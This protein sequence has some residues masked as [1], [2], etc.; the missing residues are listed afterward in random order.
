MFHVVWY[1]G[2]TE[3]VHSFDTKDEAAAFIDL[4]G[5][6]PDEFEIVENESADF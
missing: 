3:N 1:E 6:D 5:M 2:W 4:T